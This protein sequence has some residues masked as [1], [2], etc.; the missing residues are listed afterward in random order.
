LWSYSVVSSSYFRTFGFSVM[1]GRDFRDGEFARSVIVDQGTA[2][3]LW[4]SHNA[5]G[6]AI[7]FG[8]GRSRERW[9]RVVGVA[10]DE[11]DTA[12]LRRADYSWG[13]H[14]GRVYRVVAP[15]DSMPFRGSAY[16]NRVNVYAR[17]TGNTELAAVRLQ[18]LL[19]NTRG[20]ERLA[21]VP[22]VDDWI[23]VT[24][25]RQD[26]VSSLFG[27]F[28]FIGLCLVAT[29]VYGIVAHT[30]AERKR[31]LAVRISLGATARDV[32]HSV[33]REGNVLIL[34]GLAVGLLVTKYTVWWLGMFLDDQVGYDAVLMA[35]IAMGLFALAVL[36]ASIPA[37]R[38]TRIDPVEALRHD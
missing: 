5:V 16:Y 34:A 17:V 27:T 21:V 9:Y 28:A 38:A 7:K 12:T 31:E 24:R 10:G 18:R 3:Y 33:L 32:L 2:R 15:D 29:G 30:V 11:R 13:T 8:D 23:G 6:R 20:N 25:L 26:F 14:M 35:F 37:W 22:L 36:A 1:R 19:R 4:G